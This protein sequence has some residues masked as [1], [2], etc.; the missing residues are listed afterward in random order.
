VTVISVDIPRQRVA[1]TAVAVE[2]RAARTDSLTVRALRWILTCLAA[3][4]LGGIA[5]ELLYGTFGDWGSSVPAAVVI[6]WQLLVW[7]WGR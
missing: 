5:K 6:G 3:A 1:R 4:I 7:R 2:P